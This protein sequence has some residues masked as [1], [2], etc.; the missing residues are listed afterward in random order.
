MPVQFF[1]P[2]PTL[3][4]R[5]AT[6]TAVQ[7]AGKALSL[8]FGLLTVAVM[9]RYLGAEGFG[10]YTT[11]IAFLQFFGIVVDFGLSVIIVQLISAR[12]AE[13]ERLVNNTFTFRLVT[14]AVFFALAPLVAWFMP[15]PPI[16]R[17]G[18]AVA[19]GALFCTSLNQMLVGLFQRELKMGRAVAAE[20]LGRALI[21]LGAVVAVFAGWNLL[22]IMAATVVGNAFQTLLL[23]G[24]GRRFIRIRL[25]WDWA[26]WREVFLKSWPIGVSIICNLVYF[27]ADTVILSLVRDQAEVGVYG[28]A[29][30]VL[31]VLST[32][33]YLFMG[34]I[35]PLY[36]AAWASGDRARF[37]RL[38]Q[39]SWDFLSL[40]AWPLVIGGAVVARQVMVFVAGPE[41]AAAGPLLAVLLVATAMIYWSNVF[42]HAI[43]A[44]ERQRSIL[45]G[46]ALVAIA[47]LGG[48]FV[49]IP[50]YSYWGAA[51]V[52]VAAEFCIL[53]VAAA[54]SQRTVGARVRYGVSLRALLASLVMGGAVWAAQR[55]GWP[56]GVLLVIGA[57]VY[58]AAAFALG[59][60]D[61]ATVR[62]LVGRTS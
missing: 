34:L 26:V 40:C 3:I 38:V 41:F 6:N 46:F 55:A 23:I 47:A 20:V 17:W 7:F 22:A 54:I 48:Y 51:A 5:I 27:K 42:T 1:S 8:G 43:V 24:F 52:T 29:Y 19:S 60:V 39:R 44:L 37:G 35:L 16:V 50:R 28:A 59:A 13:T 30:K 12:P 4:H 53:V 31:E 25:A 10:N 49:F 2:M 11:S 36:S 9:T 61:R 62:T 18:V 58:A 45:P 57:A 14:A 15:Y 33:P 21:F 56:L 32:V